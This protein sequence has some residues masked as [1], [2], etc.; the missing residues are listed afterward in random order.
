MLNPS[1]CLRLTLTCN[2]G[3]VQ[4]LRFKVIVSQY[5][6]LMDASVRS[7]AEKFNDPSAVLDVWGSKQWPFA[8]PSGISTVTYEFEA[9]RS[10][11]N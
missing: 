4:L 6:C 5:S 7:A 1:V 10:G 2:S 3:N 11:S 8:I 9:D